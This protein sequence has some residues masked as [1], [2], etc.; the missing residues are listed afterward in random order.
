[1]ARGRYQDPRR[2]R[3]AEGGRRPRRTDP[4]PD[5][6]VHVGSPRPT[7]RRELA[8]GAERRLWTRSQQDQALALYHTGRKT[9]EEIARRLGLSE[10]TVGEMLADAYRGR[11]A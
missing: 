11:R 2:G 5:E 8:R 6:G 7:E 10:R 3:F 1:M 4:R 9:P